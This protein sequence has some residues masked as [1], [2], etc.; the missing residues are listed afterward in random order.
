MKKYNEKWKRQLDKAARTGNI[1]Q[2]QNLLAQPS[3]ARELDALSRFQEEEAADFVRQ[4]MQAAQKRL[5]LP[6][7][8]KRK[9]A[10]SIA[11]CVCVAAACLLATAGT[12]AT[13]RFTHHFFEDDGVVQYEITR[14]DLTDKQKEALA[15]APADTSVAGSTV[16]T[17]YGEMVS[18]AQE[19]EK[20]TGI[21]PLVPGYLP[22]DFDQT[23]YRVVH[24]KVS[25]DYIPDPDDGFFPASYPQT[26]FYG[27]QYRSIEINQEI[28]DGNMFSRESRRN[29]SQY[30]ESGIFTSKSGMEYLYYQPRVSRS[31][32]MEYI[33]IEEDRYTSFHF[34]GLTQEEIEDVL[35]SIE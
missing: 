1:S 22:E 24:W 31:Y 19:V 18:D 15:A 4:S 2:V 16:Y 26:C 7:I 33:S 29:S 14:T 13:G 3:A 25:G 9:K 12:Y 34:K 17:S 20:A 6:S 27:S 28:L 11:V 30:I 35:N 5:E 8:P 21:A 23:I 32:D 10:V